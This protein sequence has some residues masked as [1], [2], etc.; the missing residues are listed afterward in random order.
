[1]IRV[2]HIKKE[3]PSV[4]GPLH[5][6]DDVSF[7]VADGEIYGIIGLS[8]AGKSTLVRLLNRLE[9]PTS[10]KVYID[11][12]EMTALGPAELRKTRREIGMIF[13]SFNLFHQKTVRKNIAYPM[14]IDGWVKDQIDRRVDELLRFIG[15]EDRGDAYPAEL[16]GGQKQRVAIA[17]A[18][19]LQPKILL[20]DEGTSALDPKNTAQILDLL[21][22]LTVEYGTT[23]IMITHQMEVAKEICDRIAVMDA[24]KIIEEKPTADL[25][26]RPE[27]PI[28]KA[29]I[30]RLQDSDELG[31]LE[32]MHFEGTVVKLTYRNEEAKHSLITDVVRK[33][34]AGISILSANINTFRQG[35]IGYTVVEI[36]GSSEEQQAAIAFFRKDVDCEVIK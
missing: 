35:E 26:F 1:M 5:A 9:E 22:K 23:I 14:E 20:S 32:S 6:V 28:T 21:R 12:E 8:G 17:R 25:F 11:E 4:N 18:M 2:E 3:F 24:G 10:G 36:T 31:F 19:A 33:T 13:Q 29:F 15:L 30:S 7:T 16:S 34:N 27:H